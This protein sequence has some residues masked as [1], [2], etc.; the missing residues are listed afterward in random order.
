MRLDW[1]NADEFLTLEEMAIKKQIGEIVAEATKAVQDKNAELAAA[2]AENSFVRNL[3]T[4]T[5][6]ASLEPERRLVATV[7]RALNFLEFQVE[8]IDEKTKNAIRKE[9]L[10]VRDGGF[11]A[12][13]EVAGT[14]RQN[15]KVKEFNDILAR[16]ATI[17]KRKSDLPLPP[18][19]AL[20]GLLILN[21]DVGTH[22]SKRPTMYTGEDEHII[23]TA[24]EQNIGLLSTVELHKIIVDVK[25]G[26]LTKA[27]AREILKK[28]GRI[29]YQPGAPA[30]VS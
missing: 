26:K 22:P 5:E 13:T 8:D 21:Y 25:A 3:L 6:D 12:I 14:T 24:I 10:W 7:K 15:P 18:D 28:F 19:A 9:D 11:L 20:S 4:A 2:A 16:M 23:D 17:Y 1:I 27:A 30:F 29:E